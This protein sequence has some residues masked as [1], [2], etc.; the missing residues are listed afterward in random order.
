MPEIFG[1]CAVIIMT[2]L[3]RLLPHPPNFTPIGALALF[4]GAHMNKKI[5]WILPLS[6]M[7]FSDLLIGFHSTILFVYFSYIVISL[8]PKS[9]ISSSSLVFTSF[10]ASI[11]FF[12]VTNFGVW[13]NETTY[14]KTIQGLIHCY[15]LA[16]P[17]FGNTLLSDILFSFV[18]FYGYQ[19]IKNHTLVILK[20]VLSS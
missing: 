18:F 14:A 5:A 12:I 7:F 19:Y 8:F 20:P 11:L 17:F 1:I 9:K 15:T 2:I 16:I 13:M 10:G 3:F 6:I 4:A